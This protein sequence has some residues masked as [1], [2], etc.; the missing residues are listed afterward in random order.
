MAAP[1]PESNLWRILAFSAIVHTPLFLPVAVLFWGDNG[2][3]LFDV[4]LLQGL[5]AVAVVALEVP[6]GM[7]A[8]RLGKRT[9]LLAAATIYFL[10]MLFY[11]TGNGFWSFL[12]AELGL[13]MAGSLYSGADN[14]LIYDT[15]AALDRTREYTRWSGRARAVQ[16]ASIGVS[17]VLGGLVA[18]WSLRTTVGLSAIGPGLAMIV[19]LGFVEVQRPAGGGSL[20]KEL[21]AYRQLLRS[22]MGFVAKHRLV[23]FYVVFFAVLNGSTM[24]LL[25]LYQPYM[26]YSGLPLWAFGLAF[27]VYG[28]FAAAVGT[29][30]DRL[31]EA[32]GPRGSLVALGVL[33]IAPLM[34]MATVVHP[35]SFL[36]VL[37]HQAN[38]A[39][40]RPILTNRIL[41]FTW[42]DKRS[43]V[44][45]I[46]ALGSRLVFALTAPLIGY[47]TN[48]LSLPEA[49]WLQAGILG[50]CGVLLSVEWARVPAKYH[51]PKPI[52]EPDGGPAA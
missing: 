27:A 43:T 20:A 10:A 30:A 19:A 44:L 16:M 3:D 31:E 21:H 24:W 17:S 1:S 32:F 47:A 25:W 41:A 28:L 5:Y 23:R 4:Y 26:E 12:A 40:G 9:S 35:A 37:G 42:A 33:Q 51:T 34:L 46:A 6:T 45:S 8:D 52:P 7:V 38:R 36:F 2:L 13:A 15:L 14:A 22:A 48:A 50:V 18:T 39:I 11:S 29:F 49:L